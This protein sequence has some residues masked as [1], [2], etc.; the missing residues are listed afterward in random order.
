M[1]GFVSS[2]SK[3]LS[4]SE[5]AVLIKENLS[6]GATN[7]AA[8]M[9]TMEGLEQDY[10]E[11]IKFYELESVLINGTE[12]ERLTARAELPAAELALSSKYSIGRLNYQS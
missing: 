11:L 7:I 10:P 5:M 12:Q 8:E 3:K 6:V 1:F 2:E 4:H 9:V